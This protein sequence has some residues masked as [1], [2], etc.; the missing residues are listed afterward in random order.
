MTLQRNFTMASYKYDSTDRSALIQFYDGQ[1]RRRGIRLHDVP[2]SFADRFHRLVIALNDA[3]RTGS[4]LDRHS[5]QFMSELSDVF[6]DKLVKVDLTEPR[7]APE[8]ASEVI[9]DEPAGITLSDFLTDYLQCRTDVKTSTR[10]IYQQVQSNLLKFLG[11]SRELTSITQGDVV[12][13]GRW[14]KKTGYSRTTIDRQLSFCRTIFA[15]AVR[16]ELLTRNPFD[17]FRKP[18]RGLVSR[19]NR[20]RQHIIDRDT[21]DR[22]LDAC[23][24]AEW[25][26][27][28]ALSR[29]GG[30]RC[31]SETL[32][33]CWSHIDWQRE[34]IQIPCPK[35]EHI[36]GHGTREIP[37]FAGLRPHL[38]ACWDAA[39]PG[40]KFVISRHRPPVLKSGAGW[41][42]ANLRTMLEKII[43]RAGLTPWPRL[44]H[45]LRASRQTELADRFPSHVVCAWMGNSEAVAREHYLQVQDSHFDRAVSVMPQVML[46]GAESGRTGQKPENRQSP[47]LKAIQRE[48]AT[49]ESMRPFTMVEGG[50]E[51]P[52]CGL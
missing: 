36:E 24:D 8:P 43:N 4:G 11:A 9:P 33:L 13:F 14:M 6:F 28:V 31:P 27:L 7:P 29:F 3:Q 19:N 21:I 34:R 38:E 17:E 52:T 32:S 12:D 10:L 5:A 48:T 30:L 40:S 49:Y 22:V 39:E 15:D 26:C 16:H 46:S 45:N 25:R 37:L 35:L 42:N 44:F 23:P 1:R 51:P 2:A 20:E 41:A 50:L 18:L 47:Q